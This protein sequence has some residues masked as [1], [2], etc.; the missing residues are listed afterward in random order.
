M[1]VPNGQFKV[2]GVCLKVYPYRETSQILLIYTEEYGPLRVI[3]KG[4]KRTN[5]PLSVA[6]EPLALNHLVLYGSGTMQS[7]NQAERL[8]SFSVLRANLESMA[9]ATVASD[10]VRH[11]AKDHDPDSQRIYPL[12]IDTFRALNQPDTPWPVVSLLFHQAMLQ[13]SGYLL[14]F[15]QCVSCGEAL[16]LDNVP[17]YPFSDAMGGFFCRL[18]KGQSGA[19]HVVNV[20][21]PTMALFCDPHNR[22]HDA[23][24]E[25]AHRFLAWY[26]QQRLEKPVASFDFLFQVMAPVVHSAV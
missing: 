17:Y 23:Y 20:S 24:L 8:E 7:L 25:K 11:L 2:H 26:W 21:T 13:V 6:S 3:A 15:N 4:S 1:S 14:S 22:A 19:L 9:V 5:S 18:C 12:L 16:D 10:V